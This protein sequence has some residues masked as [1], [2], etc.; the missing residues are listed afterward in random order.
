MSPIQ[1]LRTSLAR[2]L[3]FSLVVIG[4]INLITQQSH[5]S[6][7]SLLHSLAPSVKE[8]AEKTGPQAE[9][10]DEATRARVSE[11][12][13]KLPLSFEENRGQ[14][15]KGVKYLS[16]G[17]GYTLFLTPTE[18]VLTLRKADGGARHERQAHNLFNPKSAIRTPP[19]ESQPS[20]VLRM[21]LRGA[22]PAPAVTG[23]SEM[24]VRTNYFIGNDP[25]KWHSDV[26]RFERVRYSR[27]YPGIDMV[28]YGQQ[29]QLEY[30]FEIAPGAD[31]RQIALEFA[32][33][34]RVK[35]ERKTGELILKTAGGEVRQHK[36]AAYQEEGGERR[37]VE[38]RYVMQ[39]KRKVGIK[40]GKYDRARPL[41]IDPVLSY[42]TYLG[43]GGDEW[44]RGIAVDSSG[45]AYVT[46]G[47]RSIDF[48]THNQLQTAPDHY[49]RGVVF[50][51]KLD[52]NASGTASLLYSTYLGGSGITGAEEG[53]GIAVDASGHA[54]VTGITYSTDFPT[55]NQYQAFQYNA[56]AFVTK[57]DTNA[58]GTASLLYSTYLGGNGPDYGYGIAV[59]A[60][61]IAYV[62]GWTDSSDFPT[63]N[64]F[65][66]DQ[67]YA[68][69]FVTKLDTNASGTASLL[70]STYLGGSGGGSRLPS[71]EYG[72][73][74]AV[75]SSGIAYVTGV[76]ES[77]DFPTLNQY[78]T[79]QGDTDLG[80]IDAFVTKLDTNASGT[81]SLLY[82][83]YLGGSDEDE[84]YGIAVDA[85]G[86]AY[87]TGI[88]YST[89]FPTFN[90]YQ[91]AQ[92]SP[93]AFVTK[94]DTNASGTASLLYSTYLGGSGD[95]SAS[96]GDS[97]N[98]IAVDSSGIAYVTGGTDSIDFPLLNQFETDQIS[99]DA[100]VTKLDTNASGT[101]S[102]LYS[103]RLG[104]SRCDY[105]IGIAVDSLGNVYVTGVTT[106]IDFPTLN[107]F[108]GFRSGSSDAFV[109]KLSDIATISGRVT[110]D[111]STA[112]GGV[113]LT[114]TNSYLS[115]STT[116]AGDGNY[117]FNNLPTMVNYKVKP[118]LTNYTFTPTSIVL[119]N[120]TADQPDTDFIGTLKTY[121]ISGIVKLGT[122]G[123]SDVTVTLTSPNPAGFDPRIVTTDSAGAYSL[124][125]VPAGRDY[126]VTPQKTGYQFTPANRVL[127]N[128]SANHTA[129]NFAVT[130][131]S[132]TGRITR[133]G[134][135]TAISGV[136]VTLT[137][138]TPAGYPARTAQTYASGNY[139]FYNC[140]AGRDY[141]IEPTKTGFTF[142]PTTQS[143][144][145]L[146]SDIPAGSS[147]N[148][149]GTGP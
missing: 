5:A 57:L 131:Y 63:L 38:S 25:E 100:F 115:L 29:Q 103:T 53:L 2:V 117:S 137:S 64:Q 45:H 27:V 37:E 67:D 21:K 116:T 56:D 97:G 124:T 79:F 71:L 107:P 113:T 146:S 101:A 92:N 4:P 145:N 129:V 52:T 139:Y 83:T 93:D 30:D 99:H 61:G 144:T 91:T 87:V 88:T 82:S 76:T 143:I 19:P 120:V 89:D 24:G 51:T 110:S 141:T 46:G 102:L 125:N 85:S 42:S 90:Q 121:T 6:N 36:P 26:A 111:G 35:I 22:N 17:T 18:A 114:L 122:A 54:Y 80:I 86:H 50:V 147:T 98:G 140:P 40:V 49:N 69:A 136:T 118:T 16:R 11:A 68:D 23:E 73:G 109:T 20:A 70:Y 14:V 134:T 135:S 66:T 77:L 142:T 130:V 133:T 48:P 149:T 108:R 28:Y 32:G 94:L 62:T 15:D 112:I 74:I 105:G 58:S 8:S 123:L 13:G 127:T 55:F 126:T 128:L 3:I 119:Y 60:S 138:P 96:G 104:G 59:D 78:Q 65:Q 39:G 47:T 44:S 148:F 84:G 72:N 106:S 43:S 81:A 31:A 9:T 10:V 12:Y 33:V 41:V 7:N 1:N 132:I 75:D 95:Y 34:K